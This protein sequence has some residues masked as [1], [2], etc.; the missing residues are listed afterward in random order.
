MK[1]KYPKPNKKPQRKKVKI[2]Y[3]KIFKKIKNNINKIE[4]K[5]QINRSKSMNNL[6]NEFSF[7]EISNKLIQ[8]KVVGGEIEN[9][10]NNTKF[11]NII[12][13]KLIEKSTKTKKRKIN[14]KPKGEDITYKILIKDDS[15]KDLCPYE[16]YYENVLFTIEGANPKDRQRITWHCINYRKKKNKPETCKT[17]C[18]AVIQGVRNLEDPLNIKYY[19]KENHSELC[20]NYFKNLKKNNN[21]EIQNLKGSNNDNSIKTINKEE[22]TKSDITDK[23]DFI[24]YLEKYMKNNKELKLECKDFIK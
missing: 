21:Y 4:Y 20:N 6:I 24:N 16:I 5:K 22:I 14:Y 8:Q 19:L 23:N 12:E 15:I 1:K 9:K 13:R 2:D 17:F 11:E 18:S 7:L 3:N 10:E